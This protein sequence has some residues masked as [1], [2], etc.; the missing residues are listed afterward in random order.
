MLSLERRARTLA[1]ELIRLE[2]TPAVDALAYELKLIRGLIRT[3]RYELALHDT[4][5][6]EQIPVE[7]K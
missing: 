7:I 1:A 4:D 2:G 5:H 3:L 6:A